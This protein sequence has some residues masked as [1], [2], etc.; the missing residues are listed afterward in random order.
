L[1]DWG[2]F[3][4]PGVS[5]EACPQYQLGMFITTETWRRMVVARYVGNRTHGG[6]H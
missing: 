4:N 1:E 2:A 3:Q 6:I 5:V